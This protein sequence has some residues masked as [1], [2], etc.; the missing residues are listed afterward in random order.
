MRFA[1]C[2]PAKENSLAASPCCVVIRFREFPAVL[3]AIDRLFTVTEAYDR[4]LIF[5]FR[6]MCGQ[7]QFVEVGI[8]AVLSIVFLYAVDCLGIIINIGVVLVEKIIQKKG[9]VLLNLDGHFVCAVDG[10]T[11]AALDGEGAIFGGIRGV[12]GRDGEEEGQEHQ[13]CQIQDEDA[14]SRYFHEFL[15]SFPKFCRCGV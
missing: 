12:R 10:C 6:P 3:T 4:N 8:D 2:S 5:A 15:P 14:F 1:V 9:R 13:E 11:V 7:G